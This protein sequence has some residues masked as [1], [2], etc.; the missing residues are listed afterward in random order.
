M[1]RVIAQVVLGATGNSFLVDRDIGQVGVLKVAGKQ[2]QVEGVQGQQDHEIWHPANRDG[3][4]ATPGWIKG[5]KVT[6]SEAATF[7]KGDKVTV[8]EADALAPPTAKEI[9]S[10]AIQAKVAEAVPGTVPFT[11]KPHAKLPLKASAKP[12]LTPPLD[13]TPL[14]ES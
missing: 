7:R 4:V 10:A 13:K 6:V 3:E 14:V 2:F 5:Y 11:A 9:V 8:Q 12:A 1:D